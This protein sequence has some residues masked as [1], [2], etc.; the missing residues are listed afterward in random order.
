MSIL[1]DGS[2]RVLVQGITGREASLHVPYMQRYGTRIVAG[3]SPGKGGGEVHG[4]PVYDTVRDAVRAHEVDLAVLFVSARFTR[5]AALETIES[6][7]PVAVLLAEGVPHHDAAEIVERAREVGVRVIGP[8]SQGMISPGKAKVGGTGGD[9]PDLIF[10]PGPVGVISRSG[11]MGAEVAMALTKA[12]IGQSTYVAIGGD[13]VIGSE[14]TDLLPLFDADPD[15]RAVVLFAEPGTG[16]EEAAAEFIARTG[17]AKPVVAFVS[18]EIL[19]RLPRGMHFGHTGALIEA[20]LGRPSQ[21]K[22]AL[23]AAGVRIAERFDD[24]VPLVREA[25]A[26]R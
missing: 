23:R 12:G 24:I 7:V 25:L 26:E 14:Y 21:K 11:G 19:E 10:R 15:T 18:G 1:L 22:A 9:R 2:T 5:D 3:V 4:V 16:R 20:G 6:R 17:F 13:L 8:N